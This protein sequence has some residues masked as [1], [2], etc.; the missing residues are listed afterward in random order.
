M[1][2]M[3][4]VPRR[5]PLTRV[6][7]AVRQALLPVGLSASLVMAP[8]VSHAL[9]FG[10]AELRSALGQPLDLRVSLV[11]G[12]DELANS[13][14]L[15]VDIPDQW[16]HAAKDIVP[17]GTRDL[18]PT[19]VVNSGGKA[20]IHLSTDAPLYEPALNFLLRVTWP[21]GELVQE[22]SMLV[23]FP[24]AVTPAR[25]QADAPVAQAPVV[26]AAARAKV[27]DAEGTRT[28]GPVQSGETL[29][30][31]LRTYYPSLLGQAERAGRA[32]VARNPQA[33]V[34]N[35]PSRLVSGATLE[36]PSADAL[37]GAPSATSRSV[38][39]MATAPVTLSRGAWVDYGP[40]KPG[41]TL[42]QIATRVAANG[43]GAIKPLMDSIV[44]ANPQAFVDGDMNR[45]LSGVNLRLPSAPIP[46]QAGS[47]ATTTT[48]ASVATQPAP[49]STPGKVSTP[50]A[51]AAS[52]PAAT[53]VATAG[54]AV[55]ATL[56]NEIR[57]GIQ[58]ARASIEAQRVRQDALQSRLLAVE[59]G[60]QNLS[61]RSIAQDLEIANLQQGLANSA[62]ASTVQ[63]E[64][65]APAA[66][67]AL[68]SSVTLISAPSAQ[69]SASAPL[70]EANKPASAETAAATPKP[71]QTKAAE[72]KPAQAKPAKPTVPASTSPADGA[73]GIAAYLSD[74]MTPY[75]LAGAL[76]LLLGVGT[77]GYRY[78]KRRADDLLDHRDL[79]KTAK[80]ARERIDALRQRFQED[81]DAFGDP[82]ASVDNI[83]SLQQA[84][85]GR[86][87]EEAI[88][89]YS[90]DELNTAETLIEKALRIEPKQAEY[91]ELLACIYDASG[92]ELEANII[93]AEIVEDGGTPVGKVL[94]G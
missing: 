61:R 30:Q 82:D 94:V 67:P 3:N 55:Q 43:G 9:G 69:S 72:P 33:F 27:V 81:G 15:V 84:R 28:H 70:P 8:A 16:E 64:A 90:S 86:F 34:N 29:F 35:D 22:Y 48:T 19:V 53:E 60:I 75:F 89:A 92:R 10:N 36:L 91:K 47:A 77:L 6:A 14:S 39:S 20:E 87:A 37:F 54:D 4:S 23:D 63:V 78:Y 62:P 26:R 58:A 74:S 24:Q 2:Q 38:E 65:S 44:A 46:A 52:S 7:R 17:V 85:A 68:T 40:I 18:K 59:E 56:I 1:P 13:S 71:V 41:D 42:Y 80:E 66:T 25:K 51:I 49:T 50:A 88:A 79:D 76:V 12:E 93:R 11:L 31:V 73:T 32:L 57:Q 45:L 5:A 21:E 83:V